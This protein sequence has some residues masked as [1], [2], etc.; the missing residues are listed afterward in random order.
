MD[1]ADFFAR[2][3]PLG[4]PKAGLSADLDALAAYVES[5][6]RD[7]VSPYP[8]SA[9]VT[10]G[11]AIFERQGCRDCH[12][13]ARYTDSAL[14]DGEPRLHD[15]GTLSAG[16][17]QRLGGPLLGIDTPTLVG[18]WHSP[19]YLHDGSAAT[20][21][22]VFTTRDPDNRHGETGALGPGELDDLIAFLESL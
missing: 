10:R 9:A 15:V 8:S 20:L 13:G 2:E 1:P 19:R 5:L 6:Q 16:S 18:L 11:A 3:D 14:V 22:D 7:P 12:S 21:L 17:G 4:A